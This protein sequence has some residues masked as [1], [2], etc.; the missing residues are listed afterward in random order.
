MAR[1]ILR[2]NFKNCPLTPRTTVSYKPSVD[3]ILGFWGTT[4]YFGVFNGVELAGGKTDV[5][6]CFSKWIILQGEKY[7]VKA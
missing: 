3:I 7:T 6:G 5:Y 4:D 2:G 1:V